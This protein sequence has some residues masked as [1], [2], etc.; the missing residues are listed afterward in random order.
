MRRASLALLMVVIVFISGCMEDQT[1]YLNSKY[2]QLDI[3]KLVDIKEGGYKIEG[4]GELNGESTYLYLHFCKN[5]RYVYQ[6]AGT[7]ARKEP[8][9]GS[10][11]V[12]LA[13]E[14]ITLISDET[15][16]SGKHP[17]GIIETGNGYLEQKKK[18]EIRGLGVLFYRLDKINPSDCIKLTDQ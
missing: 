8:Y 12:D 18:V 5:N 2:K 3:A 14:T 11:Q 15:N 6:E 10:Y 4:S 17:R 13:H 16:S 7:P 1:Y 9:R